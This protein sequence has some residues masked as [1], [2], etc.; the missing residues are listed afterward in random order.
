MFRHEIDVSDL[1]IW[2]D[3]KSSGSFFITLFFKYYRAV[4][5]DFQNGVHLFNLHGRRDRLLRLGRVVMEVHDIF[6][7][8]QPAY[9]HGLLIQ[10]I[11]YL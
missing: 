2:T 10:S 3:R 4:L 11:L 6:P 1:V 8:D 5:E 9:R 7:G